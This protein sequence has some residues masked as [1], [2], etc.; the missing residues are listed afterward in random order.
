MDRRRR[1][2]PQYRPRQL[3][4]AL[5]R[6]DTGATLILADI[7]RAADLPPRTPQ[8]FLRSTGLLFL[9]PLSIAGAWRVVAHLPDVSL[10]PSIPITP[11]SIDRLVTPRSG[12]ALHTQD[13]GWTSRFRPS[14]GVVQTLRSGR[15]FLAGDAAHV[16]SPVGGQGMNF[17]SQDAQNLVWKLAA[18][19]RLRPELADALL[20]S[21]QAER[22]PVTAEM[23]SR[24]RRLT[25]LA[26]AP[27]RSLRRMVS[28]AAP[29]ILSRTPA[30]QL[31]GPMLAGLNIRYRHGAIVIPDDPHS[32]ARAAPPTS[33]QRSPNEWSWRHDA[34][35]VCLVR[36][37]GVVAATGQTVAAI[38]SEISSNHP[39]LDALVRQA[40]I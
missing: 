34:Q 21:Y 32:G 17:G 6:R 40:D 26:A 1:W 4:I 12:I 29:V 39:L 13:I 15:V 25:S 11:E 30:K 7:T 27:Q 37:D 38:R 2:W 24:V 36:P 28:V 31:L 20:D 8:M 23:V 16:H 33:P 14:H 18:A 35:Q 3:G 19:D 9:I 5:R 22:H 10:D